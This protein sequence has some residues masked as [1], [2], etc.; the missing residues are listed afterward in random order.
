MDDQGGLVEAAG[1][2]RGQGAV[3]R[4]LR[5]GVGGDRVALQGQVA[6]QQLKIGRLGGH[7]ADQDGAVIERIGRRRMGIAAQHLVEAVIVPVLGI[8]RRRAFDAEAALARP[9]QIDAGLQI[10][11]ADLGQ[12]VVVERPVD[13]R[14]IG[15]GADIALQLGMG[16]EAVRTQVQVVARQFAGLQGDVARSRDMGQEFIRHVAEPAQRRHLRFHRH[17]DGAIVDMRMALG[18]KTD[19]LQIAD[20]QAGGGDVVIDAR[21]I[22]GAVELEIGMDILAGQALVEDFGPQQFGGDLEMVETIAAEVDRALGRDAQRR[23]A[24]GG[25]DVDAAPVAQGQRGVDGDLRLQQGDIAHEKIGPRRAQ[26]MKDTGLAGDLQRRQIVR[27]E[28]GRDCTQPVAPTALAGN[29]GA[30]RPI[31]MQE[32]DDHPALGRLNMAVEVEAVPIGH[33]IEAELDVVALVRR[34]QGLDLR[35]APEDMG[36]PGHAQDARVGTGNAGAQ[37]NA[38]ELQVGKIDLQ[39]GQQGLVGRGRLRRAWGQLGQAR[40]GDQRRGQVAHIDMLVEIFERAPVEMDLRRGDE[41]ALRV[42]DRDIVDGHVA[43]DRSVDPADMDA[44]AGRQGLAVDQ[45][46]QPGPARRGIDAV[47]GQPGQDQQTGQTCAAKHCDL[48]PGDLTQEMARAFEP[49]SQLIFQT[50]R[51]AGGRC[52]HRRRRG[53]PQ[54]AHWPG[55][56]RFRRDV[57][58]LVHQ[59]ACPIPT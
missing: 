29:R 41:D 15:A 34:G 53:W 59:K 19:E 49:V 35:P 38:V 33:R 9:G 58:F 32:V 55:L 5:L 51:L 7:L 22:E 11:R 36:R 45:I 12:V 26:D 1:Q 54:L 10:E 13:R 31:E 43:V 47:D 20:G 25:G 48:A 37:R 23:R 24:D 52:F 30:E 14:R 21:G 8:G 27:A 4:R 3:L 28:I 44:D 50:T 17:V 56:R 18:L 6:R 57:G 2:R 46:D 42:A 16:I 39:V 40:H